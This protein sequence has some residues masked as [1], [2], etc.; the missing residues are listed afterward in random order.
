MIRKAISSTVLIYGCLLMALASYGY[1][2]THSQVSL[3]MGLLFGGAIC[4]A[5]LAMFA[6]N[7]TGLY[8]ALVLALAMT[9][10]FSRERALDMISR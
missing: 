3:I 6:Q 2:A 5:A 1:Y 9:I 8:V 7:K 10:V 4:L